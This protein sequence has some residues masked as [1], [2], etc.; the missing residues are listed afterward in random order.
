MATHSSIIAWRISWTKE[1]GG[2]E[3]IASQRETRMK[4]LSTKNFEVLLSQ[5]F[6]KKIILTLVEN[7]E[8]ACN[9]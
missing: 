7:Y 5:G 8:L 3:S 2:L 4:H 6:R 9:T 1:P